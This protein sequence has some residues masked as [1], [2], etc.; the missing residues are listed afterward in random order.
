MK[1]KLVFLTSIL[2]GTAQ[3]SNAACTQTLGPGVDLVTIISNATAGSTICLNTGNYGN[4]I[5]DNVGKSSDVII[6]SASGNGA[7]VSFELTRSNHLRFQNL[8]LSGL[9]IRNQTTNITVSGNKFTGQ[10]LINLGANGG[11][12]YGNANILIDKNSFDNISVCTNCY[13]GRLQLIS[14]DK[15]SGITISNNH[16]GGPG[17]SDGIQNGA[18]GVVIGPG[19]VFDGIIQGNYGRHVDAYQ[20]YGQ[21]H[22]TIKGNYFLNGGSYIMTPDGGDT[23]IMTDNV[24]VGGSYYPALQMGSHKNDSFIHNTVIDL[25][26]GFSRKKE[27]TQSST[28]VIVR[29][30][31]LINSEITTSIS[32]TPGVSGCTNCT[33]T[34]NLFNLSS[35]T[36][37]T[38]NIIGI[39]S[40][41]GGSIP[42]TWGGFKLLS[43]SFGYKTA[44]DTLDVGTNYFGAGSIPNSPPV[45]LLAPTNFRIVP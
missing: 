45:K 29:D 28:N 41:T 25:A 7:I 5:L 36:S 39:P 4:V 38:N 12:S 2:M 1:L 22:T 14:D 26:V 32:D 13:E 34:H 21:S 18:Y 31:I 16:F 6:Q 42:K 8:T 20:G 37:G 24:F 33:F 30:N 23:E 44:T 43:T 17:E 11:A 40:F 15:P 27:N 35:N 10:A 3:I 19:N 9:E